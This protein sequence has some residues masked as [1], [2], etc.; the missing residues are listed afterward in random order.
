MPSLHG[1]EFRTE[2]AQTS[3]TSPNHS[4]QA[5]SGDG[6]G[7]WL[8]VDICGRREAYKKEGRWLGLK[9]LIKWLTPSNDEC[10]EKNAIGHEF[11]RMFVTVKYV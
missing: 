2:E 3:M 7:S 1:H 10:G 8:D 6:Q 5:F 11:I 9:S 4:F